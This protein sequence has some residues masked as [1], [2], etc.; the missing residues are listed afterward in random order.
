MKIV[1]ISIG[2]I[3]LVLIIAKNIK[4]KEKESNETYNYK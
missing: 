2:V 3:A 4:K 1:L